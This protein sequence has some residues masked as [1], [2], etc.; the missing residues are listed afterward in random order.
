[1]N[2]LE[3]DAES[4]DK[5]VELLVDKHPEIK[6]VQIGS[7]NVGNDNITDKC[8]Q[9][10]LTAD[11]LTKVR[12]WGARL[13]TG[14]TLKLHSNSAQHIQALTLRDCALTDKGLLLILDTCGI[15][16]ISLDVTGS[17]ITGEGFHVLQ[18]KF[19]NM[20][21]LSLKGCD[22]LTQQGL[23]DI[24]RMCGRRLQD[25]DISGTNITSQ[26]LGQL[27]GKL[28]NL[29]TLDLNWCRGLT[30]QGF[31]E[32]INISGPL[33]ETVGVW[34]SNISIEE[35]NRM[36]LSRPNLTIVD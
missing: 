32:I 36:Q 28:A 1:M 31:A 6:V 22:G 30:D 18:D 33:L 16:L 15:Q 11:G 4:C 17:R 7:L 29:K 35:Q 5:S 24:L 20:E 13:I 23:L 2:R 21:K 19:T 8:L 9:T 10:L 14:E 25:L 3:G 27:Q 26:G 34:G 12:L